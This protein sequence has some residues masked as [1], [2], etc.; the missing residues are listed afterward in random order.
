MKIDVSK[1]DL[2]W[3]WVRNEEP[4]AGVVLDV[5]DEN[6]STMIGTGEFL[7]SHRPIIVMVGDRIYSINH[8]RVWKERKDALLVGPPF[9]LPDDIV[10]LSNSRN[11]KDWAEM[12]ISKL[13]KFASDLEKDNRGRRKRKR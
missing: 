13:L 11:A 1:N 3:V 4:D 8:H 2:V 7:T 5:F 6:E 12:E 9:F 10:S